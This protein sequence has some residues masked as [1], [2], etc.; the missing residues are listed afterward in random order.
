MTQ[1]QPSTMDES[2]QGDVLASPGGAG[3]SKIYSPNMVQTRVVLAEHRT[4]WEVASP[5]RSKDPRA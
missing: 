3:K 5:I 1:C 4:R 2:K